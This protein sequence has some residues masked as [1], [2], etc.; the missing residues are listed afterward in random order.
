MSPSPGTNMP[1][2][3][4]PLPSP[5]SPPAAPLPAAPQRPA[6]QRG[7]LA[8]VL[9]ALF[10]AAVAGSGL[11]LYAHFALKPQPSNSVVGQV[12]FLSSPKAPPGS[13]DEVEV[14]I[15]QIHKAP[16]GKRYYAWLQ[17]SNDSTPPVHWSLATRNG[18]LSTSYT[19][20]HLLANKP[21]L[22]LITAENA[23]T[24]PPIVATFDPSERLYY[25]N[26]P[27]NIH[28]LDSFSIQLCPQSASKNICMS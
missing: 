12:R 7:I 19:D 27:T 23:N 22:F 6:R 28:N 4:L 14:I 11:L 18:S 21:Y 26:L 15:R 3:I 16:P 25:A 24:E 5:V 1:A 13:L 8:S 10:V 17:N 9:I 20:P 2:S